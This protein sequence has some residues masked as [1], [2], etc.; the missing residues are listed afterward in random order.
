MEELCHANVDDLNEKEKGEKILRKHISKYIKQVE[1][2]AGVFEEKDVS[3]RS[4]K[5]EQN[6]RKNIWI[7]YKK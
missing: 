7:L 2:E 4:R 1:I 5:V 6:S 3:C